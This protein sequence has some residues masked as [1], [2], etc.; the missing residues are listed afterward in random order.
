MKK[1]KKKVLV[2]GSSGFLGSHLVDALKK[3]FNVNLFDIKPSRFKSK[4]DK[5]FVGSLLNKELISKAVKGCEAIFHFAA[6][7]DIDTS[8]KNP[9]DTIQTNV[10]GTINL[11]NEA[12]KQ[13]INRLIFASTIYI[14]SDKG[15]IYRISKFCSEEIIKELV[16]KT[17]LIPTILRFGSLYGPRAPNTNLITKTILDAINKKQI[18]FHGNGEEVREY[19]HIYDAVNL[20]IKSLE[21]KYKYKNLIISGNEKYTIEDMFKVI[22]EIFKKKIKVKFIKGNKYSNHYKLTPFKQKNFLAKKILSDETIDFGQG[23]LDLIEKLE[24]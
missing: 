4:N 5:E 20:S 2:T 10:I 13:N 24:K 23:V 1:Y 15:S 18:I 16:K 7:S 6:V 21:D 12:L 11:I 22:A 9:T 17:K 14:Y 8:S 3:N 19:I